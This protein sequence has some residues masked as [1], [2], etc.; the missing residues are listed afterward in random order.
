[1]TNKQDFLAA[2]DKHGVGHAGKSL[3]LWIERGTTPGGFLTAVLCN[4]LTKAV[5][6]ADDRNV[7]LIPNYVR[8]LH[9]HA[10]SGCWGDDETV[11]K[12]R[13]GL[14][15]RG[16]TRQWRVTL[17]QEITEY[18]EATVIVEAVDRAEAAEAARHMDDHDE[19]E[20]PAEPSHRSPPEHT[21]DA[22]EE[23]AA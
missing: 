18:R 2:A 15:L 4:D 14:H 1:M 16:Q 17:G 23:V 10:P 7:E 20:W 12:W 6:K 21:I 13:H 11:D 8:L 5:S 22:V 3:W 9:N 19:V